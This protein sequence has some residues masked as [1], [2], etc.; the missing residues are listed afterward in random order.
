MVDVE[1][2]KYRYVTLVDNKFSLDD[3]FFGSPLVGSVSQN[4]IQTKTMSKQEKKQRA[5]KQTQILE[6]PNDPVYLKTCFVC[7]EAARP[8]HD[9]YRNY[10]GIV[11]YSCRAF[12]RRSHQKTLTPEFKCKK[13]GKCV[14]SIESRRKCK[15]CRYV[16]CLKAGMNPDAVLNVDQKKIRYLVSCFVLKIKA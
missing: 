15:K 1:T 9:H 6:D 5:K 12:W 2:E 4:L 13:S 14:T 7:S 8:G 3:L 10:G 16:R 11:C